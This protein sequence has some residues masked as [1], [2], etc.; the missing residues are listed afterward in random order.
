M[1]YLYLLPFK[2]GVHFKLGISKSLDGRITTHN[3][4][5]ELD[6][7]KALIVYSNKS[8]FT[9][10]LEQELLLILKDA[11]YPQKIDGHT[12]IRLM[13]DFEKALDYI[14]SKSNFLG[15]KIENYDNSNINKIVKR[16]NYYNIRYMGDLIHIRR[17][18]KIKQKEVALFLGITEDEYKNIE[19]KG[20][21]SKIKKKIAMFLILECNTINELNKDEFKASEYDLQKR[22]YI[23]SDL[24]D[25][26]SK[27]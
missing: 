26:L 10:S 6:L 24:H 20:C 3:N 15:F 25:I 7:E 14:K 16:E 18:L 22:N 9:L 2:D 4:N 8:I 27:C 11:N 19:I 17:K 23:K 5:Y 13:Q 21:E 12:E 1:T